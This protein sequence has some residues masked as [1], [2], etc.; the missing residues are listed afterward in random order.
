MI[1]PTEQGGRRKPA[2]RHRH[3]HPIP[4]LRGPFEESIIEA[5]NSRDLYLITPA[6]AAARRAHLLSSST[7]ERTCSG[8][9]RQRDGE[10][11]HP[12]WK[13]IAQMSFGVH[14]LE[15]GAARSEIDAVKIL[16]SHVN[17][18]DG[19]LQR[20]GED[21]QLASR[22]IA[23]RIVL[24]EDPF[25]NL[26]AFD[27]ILESRDCRLS[28]L[29]ISDTVDDVVERSLVAMQDALKDVEKGLQAVSVFG[30]YLR[31]LGK[32]GPRPKS[33][34]VEA[35]QRTMRANI[36]GWNRTFLHLYTQG[37]ELARLLIRL[38]SAN[39]ELRRQVAF[40]SRKYATHLSSQPATTKF[41][42]DRRQTMNPRLSRL[43]RRRTGIPTDIS[44]EMS[45]LDKPLPDRPETLRSDID[46]VFINQILYDNVTRP[47]QPQSNL[48]R[49]SAS[50]AQKRVTTFHGRPRP[51]SVA[52]FGS[53]INK[54]GFDSGVS[55]KWAANGTKDLTSFEDSPL[56][57]SKSP[58]NQRFANQPLHENTAV[59]YTNHKDANDYHSHVKPA[60]P[61]TSPSP[62]ISSRKSKLSLR[63]LGQSF[64]SQDQPGRTKSAVTAL[65]GLIRQRA[66]K[67][68]GSR[69]PD[70]E[71]DTS[72]HISPSLPQ[73]E[74]SGVVW[75]RYDPETNP[76]LPNP[77]TS[78]AVDGQS[79]RKLVGAEHHLEPDHNF[80]A[81]PSIEPTAFPE[82]RS[83]S[84]YLGR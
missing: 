26:K 32:A 56:A 10:R 31:G 60:S 1:S 40:A 4:L 7:Y 48:P 70:S 43:F 59:E 2:P 80:T 42:S 14:L 50:S 72:H 33:A 65:L 61:S 78:S 82:S 73:K 34:T 41:E 21:F 46:T 25:R 58:G 24:L 5:Q 27:A 9:W 69:G 81:L 47:A 74:L 28:I 6:D 63:S 38:S 22:D 39:S 37:Q 36:Q 71:R 67:P 52:A 54:R 55:V 35:I 29:H 57:A 16:Q 30:R 17:E 44:R 23:K 8:R 83:R 13:L 53:S 64:R 19:F 76:R 12:L 75:T 77:Y 18:V 79:R 45:S 20:T 11:Y 68:S 3:D 66:K 62:G 15:E 84:R 49:R 51:Y